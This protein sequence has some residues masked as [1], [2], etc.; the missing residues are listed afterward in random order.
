M[1]FVPVC[2]SS[3]PFPDDLA[4]EESLKRLIE[5]RKTGADPY[6]TV[7]QRKKG[8]FTLCF[9]VYCQG[10]SP[11][12]L[13]VLNR[14]TIFYVL[15][16]TT[17]RNVKLVRNGG[18]WHRSEW[19]LPLHVHGESR[20]SASSTPTNSGVNWKINTRLDIEKVLSNGRTPQKPMATIIQKSKWKKIIREES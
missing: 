20:T 17:N 10:I 13:C 4:R 15:F 16:R 19:G 12:Y 14:V 1:D 9:H 11:F 5:D 8:S 18:R 3:S 6:G 2:P 7:A